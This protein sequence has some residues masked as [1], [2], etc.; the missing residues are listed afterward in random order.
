MLQ[1]ARDARQICEL[2][3]ELAPFNFEL[4]HFY[5]FAFLHC[6]V[7]LTMFKTFN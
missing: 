3:Q 5:V 4:L 6:E 2:G 1:G 7:H